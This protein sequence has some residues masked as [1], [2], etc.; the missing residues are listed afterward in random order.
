MRYHSGDFETGGAGKLVKI[1]KKA[2]I[3][4]ALTNL[5]YTYN[6]KFT[7]IK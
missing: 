6:V 7:E 5:K 1:K 2:E 3:E 4:T